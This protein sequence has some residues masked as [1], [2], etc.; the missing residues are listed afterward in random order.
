MAPFA[1][2]QS[3]ALKAEKMLGVAEGFHVLIMPRQRRNEKYLQGCRVIL[4]RH[5]CERA[6]IAKQRLDRA[7]IMSI[8]TSSLNAIHPRVVA[9]V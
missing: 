9:Q 2:A 1:F 6:S 5:E 7:A 4:K 8:C 3:S